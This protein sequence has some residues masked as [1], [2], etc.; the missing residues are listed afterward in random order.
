MFTKSIIQ[1]TV[2]SMQ[3]KNNFKSAIEQL[4][5]RYNIEDSIFAFKNGLMQEVVDGYFVVENEYDNLN[6]AISECNINTMGI[7]IINNTFQVGTIHTKISECATD[8][9]IF[10]IKKLESIH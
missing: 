1:Q 10:D 4:M 9:P 2:E 7:R 5:E 6:A 8:K 3:M